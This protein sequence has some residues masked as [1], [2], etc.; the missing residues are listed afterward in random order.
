MCK[1]T[2][3]L[4]CPKL[5]VVNVSKFTDRLPGSAWSRI[6]SCVWGIITNSAGIIWLLVS[7]PV[8]RALTSNLQA[9]PS[10]HEDLECLWENIRLCLS[11]WSSGASSFLFP[12][13]RETSQLCSTPDRQTG[14]SSTYL[15]LQQSDA[16]S[17]SLTLTPPRRSPGFMSCFLSYMLLREPIGSVV[18]PDI[19]LCGDGSVSGCEGSYWVYSC[20]LLTPM[21]SSHM[22]IIDWNT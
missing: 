2:A 15:C 20:V 13:V 1:K 17:H 7:C 12:W 3:E 8:D 19:R 18:S 6:Q 4:F 5:S 11:G 14:L 21:H 16:P 9:K 10:C 22:N